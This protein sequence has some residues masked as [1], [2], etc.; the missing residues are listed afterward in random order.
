[1]ILA[2]TL[3]TDAT[4]ASQRAEAA[5][6]LDC[7]E[8]AR[9][10]LRVSYRVAVLGARREIVGICDRQERRDQEGARAAEPRR[11]R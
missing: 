1:V 2:P 9:Q 11:G 8:I 5:A 4:I 7:A 6:I 3:R 10:I